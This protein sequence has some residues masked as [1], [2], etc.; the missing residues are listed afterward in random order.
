MT[1][2]EKLIFLLGRTQSGLEAVAYKARNESTEELY[3]LICDFE[4]SFN[5]D[6]NEVLG[7][8]TE[9]DVDTPDSKNKNTGLGLML[10]T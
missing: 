3:D 8:N 6:L 2:L 5:R 9:E 1:K 7:M 10:W 4:Q